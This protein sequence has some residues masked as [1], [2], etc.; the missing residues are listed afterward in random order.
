VLCS[1]LHMKLDPNTPAQATE[2]KLLLTKREAARMGN[3]SVRHLE[4]LILRKAIA[5]VRLGARC[6][7]I[8]PE[9]L[10]GLIAS[11]RVRAIGEPAN[12]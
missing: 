3:F 1:A 11:H 8:R 12:H 2:P 6:V 5:V 4:N 10:K 9:D 7:R